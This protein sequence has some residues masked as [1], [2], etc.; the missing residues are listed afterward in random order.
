MLMEADFLE[1]IEALRTLVLD[2]AREID[3]LKAA[4]AEVK[5]LKA[6]IE[7]RDSGRS[8]CRSSRPSCWP[9]RA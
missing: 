9:A 7:G 4:Q 1:D 3:A 2:Q 5:R 8:R 6:I